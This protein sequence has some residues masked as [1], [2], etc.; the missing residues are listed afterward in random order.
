MTALTANRLALAL[1]AAGAPDLMVSAAR[2]GR[3]DGYRSTSPTPIQDL[4]DHCKALAPGLEPDAAQALLRVAERAQAG[5]WDPSEDETRLWKESSEG[6][7]CVRNMAAVA[8]LVFGPE[9]VI[10]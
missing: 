10:E 8:D 4:I 5:E 3:Y 7:A 6:Q 9:P 2:D 1:S